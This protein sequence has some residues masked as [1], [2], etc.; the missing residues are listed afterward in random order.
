MRSTELRSAHAPLEVSRALGLRSVIIH[1]RTRYDLVSRAPGTR[2]SLRQPLCGHY[3]GKDVA[4]SSAVAAA[5]EALERARERPEFISEG[6]K[7]SYMAFQRGYRRDFH[8]NQ[9]P[10]WRPSVGWHQSR[11]SSS[12]F[13][14][15]GSSH[16][17]PVKRIKGTQDYWNDTRTT[18]NNPEGPNALS[19]HLD[20]QRMLN[21][22]M[23]G[24]NDEPI[25][26]VPYV[27]PL[28]KLLECIEKNPV[29]GLIEYT[30]FM[31]QKCE[32]ELVQEM[33][34]SHDPRFTMRVV[35]DGRQ[36]PA[37]E[38]SSKKLARKEAASA[39]LRALLREVQGIEETEEAPGGVAQEAETK[40]LPSSSSSLLPVKSPISVLMELAQKRGEV[41]KIQLVS[42]DGPLHEHQ[43]SFCVTFGN[44]TFPAVSANSTKV[45]KQLAAEAALKELEKE[46][47]GLDVPEKAPKTQPP[48]KD[49]FSSGKPTPGNLR[50]AGSGSVEDLMRYLRTDPM[51]GI[52]EYARAKGCSTEFKLVEV[53]GPPDHLRYVFQTK[54]G[55]RWFPAACAHS[56]NKAKEDSA[57]AALRMLIIEAE[58]AKYY[59]EYNR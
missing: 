44:R 6:F 22:T 16:E 20:F 55:S 37:A 57:E 9:A 5:A 1:L 46:P 40:L 43:F 51:K 53:S 29:S 28:D 14:S 50:A 19:S 10:D 30:Q 7:I 47:G 13:T 58:K 42:H 56:R 49:V 18:D 38:A 21:K 11:Q 32:F 31:T 35:I 4:V 2:R 39:A 36:F 45:A 52:L 26:H 34:P 41:C 15:D 27:S 48:T 8:G 59:R 25:D 54:V 17:P 12:L 23:Q 3:R 33:G 24:D